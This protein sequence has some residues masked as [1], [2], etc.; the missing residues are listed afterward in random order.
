[1]FVTH[2]EVVT[3]IHGLGRV[4]QTPLLTDQIRSIVEWMGFQFFQYQLRIPQAGSE[5]FEYQLTNFPRAWLGEYQRKRYAHTDPL[6]RHCLAYVTPI[7]WSKAGE[8][9]PDAQHQF[10]Q[11]AH[12]GLKA[13]VSLPIH[14]RATEFALLHLATNRAVVRDEA[15][16]GTTLPL[17]QYL[18]ANLHEAARAIV[19]RETVLTDPAQTLTERELGCLRWAMDGKTAWETAAIMDISERTVV[20]HL[21]NAARKLGAKNRRQAI[22]CAVALG[23]LQM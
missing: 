21:S 7:V 22:A 17:A 13:G 9:D 19:H 10:A 12:H 6:L 5:P 20:F 2:E 18:A 16:L 4:T 23:I 1:M 11:A 14:G 3:R 15:D 8:G